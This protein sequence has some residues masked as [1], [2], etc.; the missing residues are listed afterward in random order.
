MLSTPDTNYVLGH[1]RLITNGLFDN[2][3]VVRDGLILFHNGIVVNDK[4]IWSSIGIDR[5]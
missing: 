4:Y 1:S 5:L 2:Q 3:P